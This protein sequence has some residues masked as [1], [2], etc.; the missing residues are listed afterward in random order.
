MEL[1]LNF[2]GYTTAYFNI[3]SSASAE[4]NM[5]FCCR[6]LILSNSENVNSLNTIVMPLQVNTEYG[7]VLLF[8]FSKNRLFEHFRAGEPL[9]L[10][11]QKP[12]EPLV[13]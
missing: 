4:E 11:I 6:A 1:I 12:P 9:R 3:S 7:R 10:R 13:K 2:S 5:P 8:Y